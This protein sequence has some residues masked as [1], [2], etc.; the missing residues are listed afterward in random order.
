MARRRFEV[1][2]FKIPPAEAI[3]QDPVWHVTYEGLVDFWVAR[4]WIVLGRE[5]DIR[6]ADIEDVREDDERGRR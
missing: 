2:M 6:Y 1:L 3:Q 5:R 4:G